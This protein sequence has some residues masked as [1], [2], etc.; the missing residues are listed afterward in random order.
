VHDVS[1]G[2]PK[3]QHEVITEMVPVRMILERAPFLQIR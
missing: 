2:K 1:Q 3:V